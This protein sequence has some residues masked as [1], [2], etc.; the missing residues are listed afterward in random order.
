L[1]AVG[2]RALPSLEV[3]GATLAVKTLVAAGNSDV[4]V[5]GQVPTLLVCAG[6]AGEHYSGG[7]IGGADTRIKAAIEIV[8]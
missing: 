1:V 6:V 5:T 4:V 3:V 8:S 7:T 2:R